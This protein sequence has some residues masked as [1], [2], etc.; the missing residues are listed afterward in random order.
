M[1]QSR[2]TEDVRLMLNKAWWTYLAILNMSHW[3]R[4]GTWASFFASNQSQS[5]SEKNDTEEE[6]C[7]NQEET[8][9]DQRKPKK[10]KTFQ[11]TWLQDHT[12]LH[13]EKEAMSC[14]F[15][16]KS[17]KTNP[18]ALAPLMFGL[19]LTEELVHVRL[20]VIKKGIEV[21]KGMQGRDSGMKCFVV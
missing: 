5:E 18:F 17:K 9:E 3:N 2:S 1:F 16:R 8:D 14:Y 10:S 7:I 6:H 12:R 4:A 13:Y 11:K 21:Y 20:P 15:C 19:E